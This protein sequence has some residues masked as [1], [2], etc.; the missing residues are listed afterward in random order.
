MLILKPDRIGVWSVMLH[1]RPFEKPI[2]ASFSTDSGGSVFYA[3]THFYCQLLHLERTLT[4]NCRTAAQTNDSAAIYPPMII[5]RNDM[6]IC[7]SRRSTTL[8]LRWLNT[9]L[10][11]GGVDEAGE[12]GNEEQDENGVDR[13]QVSFVRKF[14]YEKAPE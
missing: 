13:L 7:L 4:C 1:G 8:L 3:S 10:L 6:K 9:A 12:D 2:I 5:R 11:E 14:Y